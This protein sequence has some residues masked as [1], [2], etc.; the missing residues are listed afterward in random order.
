VFC[1]RY[2]LIFKWYNSGYFICHGSRVTHQAVTAEIRVRSR[3]SPCEIC[4]GHIGTGTG[5]NQSNSVFPRHYHP[6]NAPLSFLFACCSWLRD[7]RSKPVNPKKQW[8]FINWGGGGALFGKVF[9]LKKFFEM[10]VNWEGPSIVDDFLYLR[11][12]KFRR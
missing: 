9:S 5:F 12:N 4:D 7:K 10:L 11:F 2:E 3:S 8:S 1:V 6:R